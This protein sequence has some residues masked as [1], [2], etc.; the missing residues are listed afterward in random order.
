[1]SATNHLI[2]RDYIQQGGKQLRAAEGFGRNSRLYSQNR[3]STLQDYEFSAPL[4]SSGTTYG[5][6]VAD[7]NNDS[8]ED[9]A[10]T[11]GFLT[12]DKNADAEFLYF[13]NL[14][15]KKK[16]LEVSKNDSLSLIHI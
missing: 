6:V 11:N 9:I 16:D 1:M 5:S 8:W 14:F 2:T 4:L 13:Q 7:F 12:R 15:N 3:A 10:I